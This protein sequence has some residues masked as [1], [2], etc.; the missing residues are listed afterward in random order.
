MGK[1]ATDLQVVESSIRRRVGE[2]V[3]VDTDD[4][5][6]R[7]Q[8]NHLELNEGKGK[9]LEG[10]ENKENVGSKEGLRLS[11]TMVDAVDSDEVEEFGDESEEEE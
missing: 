7:I 5:Q 1:Q 11:I 3:Y 6:K 2:D 4:W 8:A 9:R 10:G